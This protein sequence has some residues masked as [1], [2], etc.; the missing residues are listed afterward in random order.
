M[1]GIEKPLIAA[2]PGVAVGI[3]WSIALACD[4]IVAAEDSRFGAI[5]RRIGLAPDGGM[6]WFL[7]RRAGVPRAKEIAFS[8]RMLGAEE[9]LRLGLVEHLVPTGKLLIK[10]RELAADLAS[11]PTFAFG[12]AKKLFDKAIAPSLEDFLELELLVQPSLRA[13]AD[14]GEGVAA[15]K[16]KRQPAFTGR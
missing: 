8:A 10:A 12:M 2:V 7:A 16:Q 14:H 11:G 1:H 13:S 3:G 15:F 4:I 9:A 6:A 5:F